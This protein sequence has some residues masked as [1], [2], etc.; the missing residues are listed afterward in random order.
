MRPC[1]QKSAFLIASAPSVCHDPACVDQERSVAERQEIGDQYVS[2]CEII[3]GSELKHSW[4]EHSCLIIPH[5]C[6]YL[7]KRLTGKTRLRIDL[8]FHPFALNAQKAPIG[9][10]F[11]TF[12]KADGSFRQR[13]NVGSL[14]KDLFLW[15][16]FR[17]YN[18][19]VRHN[20]QSV[21]GTLN[22]LIHAF[23]QN[24]HSDIHAD[25]YLLE[26]IS[27]RKAF[28]N[29]YINHRQLY[30]L[31]LRALWFLKER[32]IMTGSTVYIGQPRAC[33]ND[34]CAL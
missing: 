3:C 1:R 14:F 4:D 25:F 17:H 8:L 24:T 29:K 27:D 19:M 32:F 12:D 28:G 20:A 11:T 18:I 34:D 21:M 23:V 15:Q 6:Q 7:C 10:I 31:Q 2:A 33:C 22:R 16:R 5:T 26:N 9:W 30:S 13:P